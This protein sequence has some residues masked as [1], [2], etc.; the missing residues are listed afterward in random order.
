M[1][2]TS[3]KESGHSYPPGLGESA[4]ERIGAVAGSPHRGAPDRGQGE[5]G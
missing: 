2:A 4:E 5:V 3:Q 1:R